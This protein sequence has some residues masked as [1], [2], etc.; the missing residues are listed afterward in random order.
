[1]SPAD[2][3]VDIAKPILLEDDVGTAAEWYLTVRCTNNACTQLIAFQKTIHCDDHTNLRLAVT[4]QPSVDCPFCGNRV[5]F[6]IDQ[7]ER[8]KVLLTGGQVRQ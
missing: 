3:L 4:G 7:I 2:R 5:R 8:R 6:D 1:M